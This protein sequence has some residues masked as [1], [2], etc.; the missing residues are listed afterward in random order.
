[1]LIRFTSPAR[2]TLPDTSMGRSDAKRTLDLDQI[3]EIRFDFDVLRPYLNLQA[4]NRLCNLK[5]LLSHGAG[6]NTRGTYKST[7]R[8]T[9]LITPRGPDHCP[10]TRIFSTISGGGRRGGR[11]GEYVCPPREGQRASSWR[12]MRYYLHEYVYWK[13]HMALE[14]TL[15]TVHCR[16][17][18]LEDSASQ[19]TDGG[20]RARVGGHCFV[21]TPLGRRAA[22]VGGRLMTS[23]AATSAGG[24][25]IDNPI[26]E[27]DY[28]IK[29]AIT[30]SAV[31]LTAA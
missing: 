26:L 12:V 19:R 7:G 15:T 30:K 11:R 2:N 28:D 8:G 29:D 23:R 13:L 21:S 18:K 3:Q 6:I 27:L 9:I 4:F 20:V 14:V 5:D 22:A 1:M 16:V 17:S 10:P 24:R 31:E 25:V